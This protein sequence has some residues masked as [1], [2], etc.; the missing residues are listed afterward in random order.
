MRDLNR[1][2]RSGALS[3]DL[4]LQLDQELAAHDDALWL[5][6]ALKTERAYNLEASSDLFSAFPMTWQGRL[7][8][9]DM[10]SL[11]EEL[12]PILAKP[13]YESNYEFDSIIAHSYSTPISDSMVQLMFPALQAAH[14]AYHRT[15]A[16]MRCLRIL[17]ALQAYEGEE[18]TAKPN[19]LMTSTYRRR[20]CLTRSTASNLSSRELTRVGSSTPRIGTVRTTAA[21]LNLWMTWASRRW[22]IRERIEKLRNARLRL[23]TPRG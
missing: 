5:V 4:R 7:L 8:Q 22:A 9:G 3:S 12:L 16:E 15:I 20:R 21:S 19:L 23:A 1:V 18:R 6:N 2:L 11:Y 10:L 17:N 13:W 14:D